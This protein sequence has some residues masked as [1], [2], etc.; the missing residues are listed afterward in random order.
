M[1]IRFAR[2]RTALVVLLSLI[3][4]TVAVAATLFNTE[5]RRAPLSITNISDPTL[6]SGVQ[7][8]ETSTLPLAFDRD[9]TTEH[10]LFGPGEITVLL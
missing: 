3:I 2:A 6:P 10:V 1:T 5:I 8:A 9:A 4:G 7:A